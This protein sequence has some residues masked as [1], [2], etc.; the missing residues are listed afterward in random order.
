LFLAGSTAF[1]LASLVCAVAPSPWLLVAARVLQAGGGAALIPA[2]LALVLRASP[3][4]RIPVTLAIWG[5]MG[6]VA[7]A[8]GPTLG[9]AVVEAGG[10]RWVFVL[11]LPIGIL[12]VVAG[13]R[14]LVESSDPSTPLPA[15]FGVALIVAASGLVALGLVQS[16]EW[17]WADARTVAAI[18]AGF[19][20]LAAF[21]AHQRRTPAPAI[22]LAL[23]GIGNYRW[24]NVASFTFGIVFS[25]MFLSSILFLTE[26]WGYSILRAGF[27]VAPGPA[28]VAVLA[29]RIGRL[30]GRIGQRPLLVAGGLVFAAGG[31][32]RLTQLGADPAYVADYLP[33][34]LLSGVG[35]A[36]CLPQLSSVIGQALPQNRLG[37][38]GA[39]NQA[40]RQFGG[41]FG[42]ALAVAFVGQPAG[43]ADALTRFDRV[44]WLLVVGALATSIAS[45]PLRTRA[46]GRTIAATAPT[47]TT[48]VVGAEAV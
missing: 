36:L 47:P 35:V 42:V 46:A 9:A 22:D 43:L 11:N 7:G 20:V 37:V 34:M 32:V 40:V 30:A 48:V 2:S 15:P 21:V 39:A 29:P 38:G 13:R 28:L 45:L 25:A 12:T 33:S 10:W 3:P 23:F 18:V 1:T 19:V 8:V 44:W 26:V 24:G 27:A 16:D 5:A 17:G 4:E 6:A 41:T 14:V 31:V